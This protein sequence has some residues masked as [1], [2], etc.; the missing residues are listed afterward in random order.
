MKYRKLPVVIEAVIVGDAV[1]WPIDFIDAVRAG[2]INV[3]FFGSGSD[4]VSGT[5]SIETTE[6]T[7]IG[8][9]IK[10]AQEGK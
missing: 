8:D 9:M 7:M 6:G 3:N 4:R 10:P 5:V 1:N 2:S